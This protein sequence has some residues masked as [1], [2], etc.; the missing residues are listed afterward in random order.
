MIKYCENCEREFETEYPTKLYCSKS[1]AD[2]AYYKREESDY[3]FLPDSSEP[4]FSFDC[5]NCGKHVDVYSKYDQ[6]T[7]YCCGKCALAY[8]RSRERRRLAKQRYTSNIGMS[9]G[10]SLG[11]LIRRE[12]RSVDKE[13]TIY[14]NICPRCGAK[15]ETKNAAKRYCSEHCRKLDEKKRWRA[16]KCG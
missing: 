9:G 6:R 12:A 5:K 2:L 1:C 4:L 10:M 11:S 16:K 7:T 14:V 3:Q 13:E 15:F 8:A